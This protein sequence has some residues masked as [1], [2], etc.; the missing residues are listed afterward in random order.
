MAN[1][2]AQ[3][4]NS[5]ASSID[6]RLEE[7]KRSFV[8]AQPAACASKKLKLE[9][10]T[11]KKPGN[12]HQYGR[13]VKVLEKFEEAIDELDRNKI[14][15]ARSALQE[16][17]SIV[18]HRIKL[19]RISDKSSY[20]WDTVNQYE[21][22]ELASDSED[23]KKIYRSERRAE[24]ARKEKRQRKKA[25]TST[26]TTSS[27]YQQYHQTGRRLPHAQPLARDTLVDCL[28]IC[29][30]SARSELPLADMMAARSQ[31]GNSDGNGLLEDKLSLE[32]LTRNYEFEHGLPLTG[33]EGRLARWQ[34]FWFTKLNCPLF[35][36]CVLR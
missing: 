26:S 24:K 18:L 21:A 30:Q 14:E 29:K 36:K 28:A 16:G 33:V 10:Q 13:E 5:L 8:P 23:D 12:A 20:G 1:T 4:S 35:V 22:D 7:L 25:A 27:Q 6:Q 2:V 19:I 3:L 31:E 15:K 34:N 32:L 17:K 9:V 11:I